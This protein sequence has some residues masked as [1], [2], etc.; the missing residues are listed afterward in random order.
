MVSIQ[1]VT[2]R[3]FTSD[4]YQ[5]FLNG[6]NLVSGMSAVGSCAANDEEMRDLDR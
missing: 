1:G 2:I 6:H 5:R 4:E 3:Q